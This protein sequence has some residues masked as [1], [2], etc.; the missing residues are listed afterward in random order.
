MQ[1]T[2]IEANRIMA[3]REARKPQGTFIGRDIAA[4]E[5]WVLD[6]K[7]WLHCRGRQVDLGDYFEFLADMRRNNAQI[8]RRRDG[9]IVK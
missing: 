6:G 1:C 3:E 5:Y 8:L 2:E 9:S 7:A 4:N